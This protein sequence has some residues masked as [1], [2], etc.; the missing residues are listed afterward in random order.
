[1]SQDTFFLASDVQSDMLFL[2]GEEAWHCFKVLRHKA[3]DRIVATDGKGHLYEA[4]IS[5]ATQDL[6]S[7]HIL[8]QLESIDHRSFYLHIAIAP[9]KNIDRFEWFLEKATEI[10][11]DEITPILCDHSE[12]SAIRIDRC[13]RIITAAIKQSF[14]SNKPLIHPLTA[15]SEAINKPFDGMTLIAWCG[16]EPSVHLKKVYSPGQNASIFIGPEGDFSEAEIKSALEKGF[17][18]VSLGKSRLRTETAG[19]VACHAIHHMNE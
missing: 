19:V 5:I 15:F 3:G 13:E 10:G 17:T 2:T 1:M 6:C 16:Q 18:S 14:K 8:T 11:I 9:T 4:E 7:A 12:R